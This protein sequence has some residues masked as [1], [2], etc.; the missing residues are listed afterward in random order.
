MAAKPKKR[1]KAAPQFGWDFGKVTLR[2]KML[3]VAE[4]IFLLIFDGIF[5]EFCGDRPLPLDDET[6]F[7]LY[8][9]IED[10]F[11]SELLKRLLRDTREGPRTKA[12]IQT[13]AWKTATDYGCKFVRLPLH[14]ES[15]PDK[16]FTSAKAAVLALRQQHKN[17][18]R[19]TTANTFCKWLARVYVNCFDSDPENAKEPPV[20]LNL[21]EDAA[22]LDGPKRVATTMDWTIDTTDFH[23]IVTRHSSGAC[24]MPQLWMMRDEN[25]R[26]EV[27]VDSAEF[28]VVTAHG[29]YGLARRAQLRQLFNRQGLLV[30]DMQLLLSTRAKTFNEG[31]S[32]VR[33][34]LDGLPV[35]VFGLGTAKLDK[36]AM[37]V[38]CVQS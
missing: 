1:D 7:R 22:R 4:D 13:A 9:L 16:V 3:E 21:M 29:E 37:K 24:W 18:A 26:R 8:T 34:F 6:A 38:G 28:A 35:E 19:Q 2:A 11:Q 12:D 15:M 17:T 31:W 20:V 14:K 25:P 27:Y 30:V 36:E 33:P 10:R 5:Q 32:E 23:E